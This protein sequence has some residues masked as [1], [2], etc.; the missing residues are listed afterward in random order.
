[1][2]VNKV[3]ISSHAK[4]ET[5]SARLGRERGRPNHVNTYADSKLCP[6]TFN[7]AEFGTLWMIS[8][9]ELFCP[10]HVFSYRL[11]RRAIYQT[12]LWQCYAYDYSRGVWSAACAGTWANVF[13]NIFDGPNLNLQERCILSWSSL[14][15]VQPMLRTANNNGCAGSPHCWVQ[16]GQV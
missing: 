8:W 5:T 13:Y 4:T 15:Q 6:D 16:Q 10:N 11:W 2:P 14:N 3:I 1:M 9:M 12:I 7:R